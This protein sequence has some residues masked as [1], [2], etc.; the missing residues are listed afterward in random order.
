MLYHINESMLT[1]MAP[2]NALAKMNSAVLSHPLNPFSYLPHTK[3]VVANLEVF[4]DLSKRYPK[5]NFGID[6]VSVDGDR[7]SVTEQVVKQGVFGDLKLFQKDIDT[8]NQSNLL[9]VA[10]MSGHFATLLRGTV[11]EMLPDYNVYITDWHDA[12]NIPL[13][14]G[15]FSLDEYID[16]V[17]DFIESVGEKTHVLAV[18]QPVVAALAAVS[19]LSEDNSP[20]VPSSLTLMGGPI[21]ARIDP[22]VPCKLA[23]DK[24]LSW[25][26]NNLVHSVPY[27]NKGHGRKVYPG[28]L[29]LAGFIS[30]NK[31]NHFSAYRKFHKSLRK[32]RDADVF[33]HREFYDEYLAVMDLSA[34][35]YLDTI[36]KVFQEFQLARNCFYYRERLVKPSAIT[37]TALMTV[38]GENDDISSPGQTFAAH[39]LCSKLSDDMK[40]HY[41]Q[42]DAGH[43]GIFNGSKWREGVAPNVKSFIN[44]HAE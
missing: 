3:H 34:S 33:K 30:M 14:K 44:S 17:I 37:K 5:P 4:S 29:Q 21:D 10:P 19:V 22:T 31:G 32:G 28:F 24:K 23:T 43:Y 8:S 36:Q 7:V 12:R 6:E 41:L 18:C 40:A 16:Y 2:L 26:K 13:S 9:I 38:E 15:D 27:P 25:F 39:D 35:F 20:F 1:S 11:K 42:K